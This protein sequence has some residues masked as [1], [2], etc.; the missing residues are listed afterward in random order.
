MNNTGAL[1]KL[2]AKDKE[3]LR[4]LDDNFR[5]PFSKIGR[6]VKLSK[7]SVALRFEKLKEYSL[8]NMVGLNNEL[9]NLTMVR[10]YYSFDYYNEETEKAIVSEGKKHKNIQ[11]IAKYFGAYDIGICFLVD[12]FDDLTSQ[13]NKF[14]ERFAGRINRKEI[15]IISKQHYFRYN[16]LHDRPLTWVSK[17][18]KSQKKEKLSLTDKKLIRAML[19]D[20]RINLLNISR[21]L[22]ISPR[23]VSNRL[24][25]LKKSGVIMGYFMTVNPKKFN[26][27]TFKLFIQ[28]HNLKKEQEFEK[29]ISEIKNIKFFAKMLGVWDYE[30]D[31]IYPNVSELQK[32]IELMKEKFPNLIKKIEIVSLGKRIFTNEKNLYI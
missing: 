27:D 17:I 23:T 3:I 14:D 15:H 25:A 9:I 28:L 12:N 6:K 24:K 19:Y 22:N 1:P 10:V 32:Q 29:Y 7:N 18:E 11:W 16:F 5:Q 13:I 31:F 21:K 4:E 20:P 8:H 30:M 2:D 26:H